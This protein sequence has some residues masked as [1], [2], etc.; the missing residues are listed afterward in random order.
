MEKFKY[1]GK[2]IE[3]AKETALKTL[4][5]NESDI[6]INE[7]ETKSGGLFKA[8]KYEIEVVTKNQIFEAIKEF[9]TSIFSSMHIEAKYEIK[10]KDEV[11]L[12]TILSNNDNILIGR[13]GR[14]IS[15]INI[16][17]KQYLL[18]E[19]GFNFKY[20]LDVSDYKLKNQKRLEKLAKTIAKEVQKTKIDVKLDPMNSYERR[21]IHTVLSEYKNIS[22]ESVGEEPNRAIVIK[23]VE[24]K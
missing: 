21:I 13:Q 19:L 22:T 16:I 1:S 5:C 6:Y 20:N 11:P 7:L 4:N 3:E 14:T 23:Y 17:L 12:I 15:A 24:S 2:S 18:N 9:L 8:K 10:N